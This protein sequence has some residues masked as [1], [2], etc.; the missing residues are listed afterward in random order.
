MKVEQVFQLGTKA[1]IQ[2]ADRAHSISSIAVI[3]RL[4]GCEPIRVSIRPDESAVDFMP[5]TN[6]TWQN[7]VII[8]LAAGCGLRKWT[9][10]TIKDFGIDEDRL[11][12][13]R[14]VERFSSDPDADFKTLD[15]RCDAMVARNWQGISCFATH[16]V[17]EERLT[18]ETLSKALDENLNYAM[19]LNP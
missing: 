6:T 4:L 1:H 16:L 19:S 8:N 5:D 2:I 14:I 9:R 7:A 17:E 12:A 15:A 3:G 13:R 10:E 11:A 18:F